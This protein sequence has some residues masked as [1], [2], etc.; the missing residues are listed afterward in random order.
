MTLPR[1]AT[2]VEVGPR[3]GLQSQPHALTTDQKVEW[4]TAL[5]EAGHRRIEAGSFVS[6][7][8]VPAMADSAE[9]FARLPRL[10]GVAYSALVPNVRGLEAALAAR[11]DEVAVFTAASETFSQK[12]TNGSVA[13]VLSRAREVAAETRAAG[14]PLRGYVSTIVACPYEGP[15]TPVQVWPVVE[16]LFEMGCH[17]VSLGDTI[18]IANP[19]QVRRF[20]S[21]AVRRWPVNRLAVHF[22]D[23]AGRALANCWEALQLGITVFDASGGGLG[24]CPYAPGAS[25]N[26]ASDDLDDLF[27]QLDVQTGLEPAGLARASR[28]LA[29][30]IPT[31]LPSRVAAR[32][33]A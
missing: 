12:N 8:W 10:D 3:D 30:W 7:K 21:E 33:D 2:I 27:K 23:T 29:S 20:L 16:A 19:L 9:V 6:P 25:G 24:G 5:A 11:A 18:G 17:E 32:S 1:T 14:I 28:L 13:D 31:P 15:I 4:I 22:H 26:V